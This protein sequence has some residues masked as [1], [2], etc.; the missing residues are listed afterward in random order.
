[1]NWQTYENLTVAELEEILLEELNFIQ[2]G[3]FNI[4]KSMLC[5]IKMPFFFREVAFQQTG[6]GYE[7][8]EGEV[9]NL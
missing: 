6:K 2:D 4:N 1:M 7:T 3:H 9:V 8:T 5:K